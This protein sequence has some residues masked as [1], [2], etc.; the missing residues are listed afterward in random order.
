VKLHLAPKVGKTESQIENVG[1]DF[2]TS[3]LYLHGSSDC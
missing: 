3:T 2:T 1:P